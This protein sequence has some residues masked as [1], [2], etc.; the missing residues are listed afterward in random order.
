FSRAR[1][2][3][4]LVVVRCAEPDVRARALFV[5]AQIETVSGKPTAGP[6]W[7][8]L[9]RKYPESS[10]ADDALFNEA[11]AARRS[12]DVEKERALSRDS[13]REAARA[14]LVW[15]VEGRPLTYYGLLA[16]GRLAD[17][18]PDR[19]RA[20]EAAQDVLLRTRP[21]PALHAGMLAR[22]PHLL[23]AIELVRL[24]L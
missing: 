6:L 22:D 10:L 15:L 8:A 24:G 18:D 14:D 12:S 1:A 5:L 23:A 17:L 7:E 20:I 9:A 21:P 19:A 13:A 3:L 11:V 2:A 4:A 16:H